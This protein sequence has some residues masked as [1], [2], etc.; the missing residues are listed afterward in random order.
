MTFTPLASRTIYKARSSSQTHAARR[1]PSCPR[2]T[3]EMGTPP[4]LVVGGIALQGFRVWLQGFLIYCWGT[5]HS[6]LLPLSALLS[7]SHLDEQSLLFCIFTCFSAFEVHGK[8]YFP[9]LL[10][11]SQVKGVGFNIPRLFT[12]LTSTLLLDLGS[13]SSLS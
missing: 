12:S 9:I 5:C 13:F 2:Q 3:L 4:P 8:N 6:P 10:N 1:I 11:F 7:K